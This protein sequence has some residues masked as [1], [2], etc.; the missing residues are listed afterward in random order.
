MDFTFRKTTFLV[1]S[2]QHNLDA[3]SLCSGM[4]DHL[5]PVGHL[6]LGLQGV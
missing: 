1:K 2:N 4:Q 6:T 3:Q 5:L